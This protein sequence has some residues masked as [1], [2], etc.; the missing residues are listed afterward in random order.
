MPTISRVDKQIS[1]MIALPLA[2]SFCG[3]HV[4]RVKLSCFAVAF[5]TINIVFQVKCIL[6]P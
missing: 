4:I 2:L 3:L 1:T 6:L 5:A